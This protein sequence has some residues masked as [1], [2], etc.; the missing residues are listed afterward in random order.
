MFLWVE[1][2]LVV[3]EYLVLLKLPS[4]MLYRFY[5]LEFVSYRSSGANGVGLTFSFTLEII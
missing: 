2:L 5:P 4:L 3:G 1:M